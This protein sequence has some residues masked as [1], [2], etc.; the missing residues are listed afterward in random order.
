M[1]AKHYKQTAIK[2]A[3]DV[4]AGQ[5]II[6]EDVVNACRRFQQDLQRE[7]IELRM[8]DP[9]LAI[10]IIQTMMV[11]R[12][13]EAL[14]G[15]PMMGKPFILEPFQIFIVV[16]LLGWYYT[17]TQVRRFKEAFIELARKNG[18]ALSLDTQ[19]PTPDG[20]KKMEDVHPGSYV[21]GRDGQPVKVLI[22]SEIFH[23]Q[24]YRVTFEDGSSVKASADHIWTVKTKTTARTARRPLKDPN[25]WFVNHEARDND[26]FVNRTTSELAG[27]YA[28]VRKDGKGIE[29]KYRVPAAGPVAYSEQN[30]PVDPYTFGVWLGDGT[31]VSATMTC[32]EDDLQEMISILE[33]EG[34]RCAVRRHK[35]RA[36]TI[37]L[38]KKEHG[39]HNELLDG[40]RAAGVYADKHIPDVYLRSSIEQRWA[41]LQ[42]L[43]DTDGTISK[44]GECEFTQKSEKLSRDVLELIR[45]LGIKASMK[46]KGAICNGK[47]A[48]TVYRIIFY[49]DAQH[50]CFRLSRKRAR[51]K[52]R[53]A[54]RA[55]AKSIVKIEEIETEPSKCIAVNSPDHLYLCS[56]GF[57]ATHNT[58]LIAAL[59]FAV[60][61]IQRRSGSRIYIVAAALKQTMEAFNFIRF[62]LEYKK[63]DQ[64]FEIKDN[65]FEHSI[66]YQFKKPDGTPDGM[67]EIYA[68]PSNPDSQDSFNCNF[69]IA[70]E[71]AAYKKPAQYNRFKEAQKAYTNKLMIGITTAGDNINSFGY[72]RTEYAAKVAQGII[73]DDAFF[74]FVARA[75]QDEKGN[76]DYL[77]PVQHQKANPNYGVTIRPEDMMAD[78]YQAQNDP[79]QR[80]DFLSRSLNIYTAA[81]KAWFDLDEFKASDQKYDW[82]I[83]QLAKLPVKWY[84]GADLSRTYDLTAAALFGQLNG[85]DIIITH[86]FFPIT[87][88]A[89][90]QDEDGIPLFGWKDDGW[91]TLCNNPTVNAADV[92]NWFV[93]MRSKGFKIQEIGHDRKFAGEEY[94]P[95]MKAEHFRIVDQPQYF[96]LKSQG[97][98]HIE[99]AAKD[100][101]LYYLHS[102]AY[103][104][105]VSNVKAIEKTDDAVQYEKI[106][107]RQRIDLF[108]ASVFACIRCL[109]DTE[110]Q[111]Q[112]GGWFG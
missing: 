104:Y 22:E 53:L 6:G 32:G 35:G 110:K 14:D 61:I 9:D 106:N 90:K 62:S 111:K 70:D 51:L 37:S 88:A 73:E 11:H 33:G 26:G 91:L 28:R 74:S 55:N 84:G 99:K 101:R 13:G 67:L 41:L 89:A 76:V 47:D 39:K 66:K 72:N 25:R 17:G 36:P 68:M 23:K 96:Y 15:T 98:R 85:V 83:Q 30:L 100:G 93:D 56:E 103:E 4:V 44:A 69:A 16:N 75:D 43:M 80:K 105:C 78:A 12:Q 63:I 52:E 10:N 45:S 87:Q 64:M 109:E 95:M 79:Q 54:N 19:I 65:S 97:F 59:A 94:M 27:D 29:Y 40:L 81:M 71:V 102:S 24:M 46:E 21:Y 31:S 60:G 2:Y 107:P 1:P 8:R 7:D 58:S 77:D 48:G 42:G 34:H 82:T 50:P 112:L 3:E 108:D 92:V 20:W 5:V 57:T 38:D 18:K 86:G 49:T